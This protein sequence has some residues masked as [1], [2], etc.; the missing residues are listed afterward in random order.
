MCCV[1]PSVLVRKQWCVI[2]FVVLTASHGQG[3]EAHKPGWNC[4]HYWLY[5]KSG[6]YPR[7]SPGGAHD[8]QH[9]QLSRICLECQYISW[10]LPFGRSVLKQRLKTGSWYFSPLQYASNHHCSFMGNVREHLS[11]GWL[12][13]F[14][15]NL[16]QK[17]LNEDPGA[18]CGTWHGLVVV[19]LMHVRHEY[20]IYYTFTLWPSQVQEQ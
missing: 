18:G 3:A 6:V 16:Q 14:T 7:I 20:I 5:S 19:V 10:V 17:C 11:P 2:H 12:N 9:S 4:H 15:C 8:H 1:D 13:C